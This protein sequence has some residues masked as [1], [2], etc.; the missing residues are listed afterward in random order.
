MSHRFFSG[1][2]CAAV[3][4]W[5]IAAT[6]FA[7]KGHAPSSQPKANG[8]IMLNGVWTIETE[9]PVEGAR[10]SASFLPAATRIELS[11][12][13]PTRAAVE[14]SRRDELGGHAK[15]LKPLPDKICASGLA[16]EVC[17]GGVPLNAAEPSSYDVVFSF[18]RWTRK[19]LDLPL[20]SFFADQGAKA[21]SQFVLISIPSLAVDWELWING[22]NQ[23]TGRYVV[24]TAPKR[25]HNVAQI[26]RRVADGKPR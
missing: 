23:M 16:V 1:A 26:W 10:L 2:V 18:S 21:D 15:L 11:V 24:T 8:H 7:Q 9:N 13:G 6:A 4:G 20:N 3:L 19:D 22:K 5:S 12:L 14:E 25:S 17:P